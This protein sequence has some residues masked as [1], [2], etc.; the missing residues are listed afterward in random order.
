MTAKIDNAFTTCLCICASL[1][2]WHKPL[3][4]LN[5][6]F[7]QRNLAMKP[8]N[9]DCKDC[10]TH[11]TKK[12]CQTL[13]F[14]DCCC[15]GF[16]NLV[17]FC[18]FLASWVF[19]S[20]CFFLFCFFGFMGLAILFFFFCFFWFHGSCNPCNLGLWVSLLGFLVGNLY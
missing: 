2:V 20:C 15:H 19:Q 5:T 9:Q 18:F 3:T 6:N 8:T 16:C 1:H 10:E 4:A 12:Q 14:Q 17:F 11:E 13:R 7:P